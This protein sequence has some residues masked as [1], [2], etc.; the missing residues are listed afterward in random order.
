MHAI[1][2]ALKGD[3]EMDGHQ[4]ALVDQYVAF[5]CDALAPYA[6][7]PKAELHLRC[8][9]IIGAATRSRGT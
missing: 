6:A 1:A 2:A 4:Q 8:V 3:G 5:Y 9:A 7:V